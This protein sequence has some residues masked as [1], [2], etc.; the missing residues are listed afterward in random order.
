MELGHGLG[1]VKSVTTTV[2]IASTTNAAPAPQKDSSRS[3]PKSN[4]PVNL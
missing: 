4:Q 1:L 3:E 2:T